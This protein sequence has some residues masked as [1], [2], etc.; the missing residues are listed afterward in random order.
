MMMV[1]FRA[2]K[3]HTAFLF[4][5]ILVPPKSYETWGQLFESALLVPRARRVCSEAEL[6]FENESRYITGG[7]NVLF[8]IGR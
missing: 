8:D 1:Q 5:R 3:K 2:L 6:Q 7:L 4:P